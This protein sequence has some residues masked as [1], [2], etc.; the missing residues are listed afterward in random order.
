MNRGYDALSGRPQREELTAQYCTN[1]HSNGFANPAPPA[2][3]EKFCKVCAAESL[4]GCP[5][6]QTKFPAYMMIS[7]AP[8]FC[9]GCGKP[10]PWTVQAQEA[11]VELAELQDN[12]STADRELLKKSLDDL[13][14]D[15]P[16]TTVATQRVKMLLAKAGK[17]ALESFR[18]ILV[19]IVTEAV[20][21]QLFPN[22]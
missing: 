22:P 8:P 15:T 10:L 17:P 20:K 19:N 12:L 6:C 1:G 16:Q 21:K 13:I 7:P 3:R 4:A 18:S 5:H 2:V 9:S 11:A 14:R